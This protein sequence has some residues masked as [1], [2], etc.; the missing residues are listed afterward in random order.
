MPLFVVRKVGDALNE[1]GK[2]L[3]GSKVLILGGAYKNDIDD[4]REQTER[5]ITIA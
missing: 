2:A 1:E 4:L 5:P 3:R